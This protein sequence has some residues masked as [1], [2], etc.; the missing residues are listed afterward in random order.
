MGDK[1]TEM[2][3]E[4]WQR[5]SSPPSEGIRPADSLNSDVRPPEP[6][7][8][9]FLLFKSPTC[10][11][12]VTK[13]RANQYN[14]HCAVRFRIAWILFRDCKYLISLFGSQLQ[15]MPVSHLF[16]NNCKCHCFLQTSR[17]SLSK[18]HFLGTKEGVWR[19]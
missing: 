10:G 11:T 1:T 3:R 12:L 4:A 13:A 16:L 19:E 6:G 14:R 8:L 7:D 18:A 15:T 9:T 5:L 2:R 17:P